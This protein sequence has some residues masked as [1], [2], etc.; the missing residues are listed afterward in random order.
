MP[1]ILVIHLKR[2]T[3]GTFRKEKLNHNIVFPINDLSLD[4][5]CSESSLFTNNK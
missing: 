3:Y 1:K 2:F 4:N 5:V